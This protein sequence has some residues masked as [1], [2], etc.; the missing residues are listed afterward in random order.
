MEVLCNLGL[1]NYYGEV[2]LA[3]YGE[4]ILFIIRKL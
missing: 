3:Q 2:K 4:K 1:S